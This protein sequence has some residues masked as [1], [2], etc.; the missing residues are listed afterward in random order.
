[1]KR[2]L[3]TLFA[4]AASSFILVTIGCKK[5]NSTPGASGAFSATMSGTAYQPSVV[6]AFD[7]QSFI[8]VEGLQLTSGDSVSLQ[9]S[10]P[11]T[12]SVTS[13]VSFDAADIEYFDTKGSIAFSSTNSPSHG[14][15]TFSTLDKTNKKI[16]GK[17]N[18][19]L[20]GNNNDSVV[21]TN[22][23]FN[24]AYQQF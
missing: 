14:A 13:V 10:I 24:T 9:V 23:Q 21:V 7:Q 5:S 15:I 19:V 3:F 20:Y 6:A 4:L 11:D 16:T 2:Q 18:G 1:M 12:A 22:G 17:F 8:N